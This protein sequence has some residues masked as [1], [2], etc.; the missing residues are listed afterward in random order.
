MKCLTLIS[1]YFTFCE[2]HINVYKHGCTILTIL[3]FVYYFGTV[4]FLSNS[5]SNTKCINLSF[6]LACLFLQHVIITIVIVIFSL[7][8][9]SCLVTL[10]C[11]KH[12]FSSSYYYSFI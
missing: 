5:S 6:G 9:C 2:Q 8:R 4:V 12:N 1:K 3:L 7:G 11:F 10:L